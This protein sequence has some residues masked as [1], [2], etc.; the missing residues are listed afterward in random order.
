[1]EGRGAPCGGEGGHHEEGRRGDGGKGTSEQAVRYL[2][3]SSMP[4]YLGFT[5][6]SACILQYILYLVY[7][8]RR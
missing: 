2:A 7:Y 1:M 8:A 3:Q 4:R 5:L 6:S